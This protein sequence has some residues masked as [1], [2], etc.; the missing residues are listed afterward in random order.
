MDVW[1][2]LMEPDGNAAA[3]PRQQPDG[4]ISEIAS[5]LISAGNRIK[6]I[7]DRLLLV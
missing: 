5:R 3:W 1:V 7:T 4:Q 2:Y 6:S